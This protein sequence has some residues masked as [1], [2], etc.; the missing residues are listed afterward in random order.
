MKQGAARQTGDARREQIVRAALKIIAARGV[1]G[2]TTAVLARETGISEANLYRHFKNKDDIY[3]AT[4]GQIRDRITKNLEKV[5]AVSSDPLRV[6]KRFF[7]LQVELMEKN[8][9]IPRLMFSEELH[10][11]KNMRDRILKTMYSVSET[12]ASLVR[13]GQKQGTIRKDIDAM[14]TV[15][16]LVAL[17]QGLAFRWSLEGFSFSLRKEAGATWKDFEKLIT[18][19]TTASGRIA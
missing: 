4:V 13:D 12:L 8:N 16:M 5:L 10:V 2:L 15:L 7:T 14:K 11:H 9:G 17:M 19:K 1:S 6:L 3:M 18:A